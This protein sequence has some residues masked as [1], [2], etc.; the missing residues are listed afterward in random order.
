MNRAALQSEMI[1]FIASME[2]TYNPHFGSKRNYTYK[3]ARPRKE[4]VRLLRCH[5]RFGESR[6]VGSW[7]C[8]CILQFGQSVLLK[9]DFPTSIGNYTKSIELYPYL[10]EAYYNRGWYKFTWKKK[11][12]VVWTSRQPENWVFKMRIA[13]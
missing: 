3:S 6:S 4:G 12:K 5:R 2:A 8:V 11:K 9:G 7:F 1:E 13:S 10:A